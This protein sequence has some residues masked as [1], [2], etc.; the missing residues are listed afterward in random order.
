MKAGE[1]VCEME[2]EESVG[3][4]RDGI[5]AVVSRLLGEFALISL[6]FS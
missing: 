6:L 2:A 3:A 4:A 1:E 5:S